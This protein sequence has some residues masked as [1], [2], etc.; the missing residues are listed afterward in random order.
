MIFGLKDVAEKPHF[1]AYARREIVRD[2]SHVEEGL[3][4]RHELGELRSLQVSIGSLNNAGLASAFPQRMM[5]AET[6]PVAEEPRVRLPFHRER[7]AA[8]WGSGK[9]PA[10]PEI[11]ATLLV[12]RVENDP[13]PI[14]LLL[15]RDVLQTPR[16]RTPV[17][18]PD[19]SVD[20][21]HHL[22]AAQS[23]M[24]QLAVRVRRLEGTGA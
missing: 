18:I 1:G 14:A 4:R 5:H 11:D 19:C 8:G 3:M 15:Q 21:L 7:D 12:N 17:V 20:P 22:G 23:N 9:N 10:P 2:G 24:A 6:D 16:H 13:K